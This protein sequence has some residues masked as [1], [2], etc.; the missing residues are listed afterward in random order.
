MKQLYKKLIFIIVGV[1]VI[2]SGLLVIRAVNNRG[3][4]PYI[5]LKMDEGYGQ[6]VYDNSGNV[7]AT[8][9]SSTDISSS[10]PTW[11]TEDECKTGQ[12]LYFDGSNDYASIPDFALE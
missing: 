11:K 12:C 2:A 8:L 6:T 3:D 4:T 9:A 5:Y 1:A 7:N 10:D